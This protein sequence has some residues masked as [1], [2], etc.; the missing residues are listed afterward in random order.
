[1]SSLIF[2][3]EKEQALV[4]TDTLGVSH[5]GDP[6]MFTTKSIFIP[7]L[8]TII[9][10]TGQGGFANEWATHVNT[11]MILKGLHNLD[12]HTPSGLRE[13]WEDYKNRHNNPEGFTTTVYQIGFSEETNEVA[14]FAYRSTNDFKSEQLEY[15]TYVKPECRVLDG[16]LLEIIPNMMLE[17]REIQSNE[18]AEER[19]YIGGEI[20]AF[21]LTQNGCNIFKLGEFPDF[22]NQE[23]EIELNFSRNGC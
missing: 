14:S 4:A 18:P 6:F 23:K 15:G 8:K 10:G 7:H 22:K 2:Y 11:R 9:A 5:G 16:N 13:F 21:H 19:V 3:T 20:Y 17:Q 12:Y 1:M